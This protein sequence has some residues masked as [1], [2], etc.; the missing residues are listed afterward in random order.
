MNELLLTDEEM[1]WLEEVL[2]CRIREGMGE[3]IPLICDLHG[4]VK[5]LMEAPRIERVFEPLIT[6]D[7]WV[8]NLNQSGEKH[9]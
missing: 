6:D 1:R 7:R 5:R 3:D 8:Q 4:K 2:Y 9:E